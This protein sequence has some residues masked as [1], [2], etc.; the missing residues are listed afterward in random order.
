MELVTREALVCDC[1]LLLSNTQ[2][3][4]YVC[5]SLQF[6]L[7]VITINDSVLLVNQPG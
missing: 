5:S 7:Q 6:L 1:V 2:V 3:C 4:V